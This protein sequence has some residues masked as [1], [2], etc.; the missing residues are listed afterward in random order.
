MTCTNLCFELPKPACYQIFN[1]D[2]TDNYS[3]T[4]DEGVITAGGLQ[5][6]WVN[7]GRGFR[8][9]SLFCPSD[10]VAQIDTLTPIVIDCGCGDDVDGTITYGVTINGLNDCGVNFQKT[11]PAYVCCDGTETT[12]V[13]ALKTVINAD[14]DRLVNATGTTTLILTARTAGLPFL[15]TVRSTQFTTVISTP[16]TIEFGSAQDL[17]DKWGISASELD[18]GGTYEVMVVKYWDSTVDTAN[19][20]G[21]GVQAYAGGATSYLESVIWKTCYLIVQTDA[22]TAEGFVLSNSGKLCSIF[23]GTATAAKY[24]AVSTGQCPC[25]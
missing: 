13:T 2:D 25:V 21:A 14:P 23:A 9:P 4:F 15:A 5:I 1:D 17:I 24:F 7:L 19:P 18:S 22:G 3:L 10:A 20:H 11:Y 16:N 12:I 8:Q 6:P